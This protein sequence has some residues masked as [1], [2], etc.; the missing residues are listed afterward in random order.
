MLPDWKGDKL[1]GIVKN[2][3]RYYESSTSEGNYNAMYE[4]SLYE[5]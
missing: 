5:V 2:R 4:K 1:M 3:V